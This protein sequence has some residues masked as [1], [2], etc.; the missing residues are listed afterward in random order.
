[1]ENTFICMFKGFFFGGGGLG[2]ILGFFLV[3]LHT[4]FFC[5]GGDFISS[6]ISSGNVSLMMEGGEN[7]TLASFCKDLLWKIDIMKTIAVQKS[8]I[9]KKNSFVWSCILFQRPEIQNFTQLSNSVVGDWIKNSSVNHTIHVHTMRKTCY[10]WQCIV[11]W[12]FGRR[13]N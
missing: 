9:K 2:L 5:L 6:K 4:L 12:F 10:I 1:M 13:L 8:N 11:L 7:S 3:F